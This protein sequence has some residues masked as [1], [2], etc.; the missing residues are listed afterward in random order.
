[1][2]ANHFPFFV[3]SKWYTLH[4]DCNYISASTNVSNK[5]QKFKP[6]CRT[7]KPLSFFG[8]NIHFGTFKVSNWALKSEESESDNNQRHIRITRNQTNRSD[9]DQ[10]NDMR[11]K[12]GENEK[13]PFFLVI[14]TCCRLGFICTLNIIL[15]I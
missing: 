4:A 10:S 6:N 7:H 11:T 12:L 13:K 15:W 1:M 2:K 9:T 8:S 14:H 3:N 5:S